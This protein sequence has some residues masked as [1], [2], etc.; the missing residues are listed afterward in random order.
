MKI[1]EIL[2]IECENTQSIHLVRDSKFW[3]AWET[4][5][6][7]FHRLFRPFKI[8]C[9]FFKVVACDMVYLG[10]PDMLLTTIE[11]ESLENG[12]GFARAD[13]NH[14]VIS[15]LANQ[16]VFAEWKREVLVGKKS[17]EKTGR[18]DSEKPVSIKA[19]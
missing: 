18:T 12:Y 3:Q 2:T 11:K 19:C 4:S 1:E 7:Y 14:I 9:R 13:E 5:A 10:F 6:F 8:N 16:G 15:G 17:V